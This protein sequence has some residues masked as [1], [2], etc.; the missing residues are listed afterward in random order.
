MNKKIMLMVGLLALPLGTAAL[1]SNPETAQAKVHYIHTPKALRG[2]YHGELTL[3]GVT[4]KGKPYYMGGTYVVSKHYLTQ[5]G[6]QMDTY[7][8]KIVKTTRYH[9]KFISGKEFKKQRVYKFKA[10]NIYSHG[11]HTQWL[12][13]L[14]YKG[15]TYLFNGDNSFKKLKKHV[16]NADYIYIKGKVPGIGYNY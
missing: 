16:T 15:H 13:Q 9:H 8:I 5:G 12:G 10:A 4:S 14:Q 11:Y 7:P 1:N 6:L 3:G 2:H